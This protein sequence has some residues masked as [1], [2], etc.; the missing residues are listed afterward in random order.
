MTGKS[1]TRAM[2]K[3]RP[4]KGIGAFAAK[5]QRQTLPALRIEPA[6]HRQT[7]SARHSEQVEIVMSAHTDSCALM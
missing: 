2:K 4:T 6:R 3:L 7:T 5:I 1:R